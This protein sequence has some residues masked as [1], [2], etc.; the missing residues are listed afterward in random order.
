MSFK[1]RFKIFVI[2]MILGSC[3]VAF[4]LYQ[5]GL[6]TKKGDDNSPQAS[7]VAAVDGIRKAYDTRGEPLQS[8]LIA[9][10][11]IQTMASTNLQ[12]RAFILKGD[13]PGQ[14]LRVE[15]TQER[16]SDG[17][18]TRVIDWSVMAA[19]QVV[20]TL[21]ADTLPTDLVTPLKA[22]NYRLLERGDSDDSYVIQINDESIDGIYVAIDRI[23]GMSDVVVE[24]APRY[25]D[26]QNEIM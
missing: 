26:K 15:E 13:Y 6:D 14:L 17:Q 10:E 9:D 2:G 8:R 22:W 21:K 5:R 11:K 1:E 24:V 7:L 25:F 19:D 16:L 4:I 3:V 18:Y 23:Q 20:V 12:K